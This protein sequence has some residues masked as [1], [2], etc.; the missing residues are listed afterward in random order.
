MK[1]KGLKD[2][3]SVDRVS[4]ACPLEAG[5][6]FILGA[7]RYSVRVSEMALQRPKHFNRFYQ[8][9]LKHSISKAL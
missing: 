1:D 4:E 8:V 6:H 3:V 7:S 9:V 5:S 2:E